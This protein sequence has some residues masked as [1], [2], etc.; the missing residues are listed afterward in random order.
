[1]A[2]CSSSSSPSS[3]S[4]SAPKA[5][6]TLSVLTTSVASAL[7]RDSSQGSTSGLA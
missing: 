7:D 5:G 3:T 1:L 4:T 6:Q 2:A